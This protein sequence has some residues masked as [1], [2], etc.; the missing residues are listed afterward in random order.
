M[1]PE[2]VGERR[3]LDQVLA[4]EHGA[5]GRVDDRVVVGGVAR[6]VGQVPRQPRPAPA[7]E[8]HQAGE[9]AARE[10]RRAAHAGRPVDDL[11]RPLH[12]HLALERAQRLDGAEPR[13]R[14][15]DL[16]RR[17]GRRAE[18]APAAVEADAHPAVEGRDPAVGL[19][20]AQMREAGAARGRARR[21]LEAVD[22][23]RGQAEH[24]AVRAH[25]VE[26]DVRAVASGGPR[27]RPVDGLDAPARRRRRASRVGLLC[28]A[29]AGSASSE[30]AT[31]AATPAI[32][33]PEKRLSCSSSARGMGQPNP[34]A[35]K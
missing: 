4:E 13:R 29:D 31:S 15:V 27:Q 19:A 6:A 5:A 10:P 11:D 16:R 30:P 25:P 2:H 20:V 12:P 18:D 33:R 8:Q 35:I 24:R 9:V 14:R 7:A 21:Q 32:H 34:A 26:R 17:R 23:V 1:A 28:A 22:V 3:V